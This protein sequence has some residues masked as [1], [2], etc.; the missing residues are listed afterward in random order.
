[1]TALLEALR[2]G[3]DVHVVTNPNLMII[4]QLLTAG[5]W[6]SRCVK[7]MIRRYQAIELSENGVRRGK[8]RVSHFKGLEPSQPQRQPDLE[9]T[10]VGGEEPVHSHIKLT[11]VD[12]EFTLLGSGN[13]DRASWYTSQELGILFHSANFAIMAKA[14]IDAVLEQR[15]ESRYDSEA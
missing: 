4:E 10:R 5:T 12:A 9:M 11:I 2:R 15:L 3:V 6:T 8:L 14:A 7:K 13:M 1:M